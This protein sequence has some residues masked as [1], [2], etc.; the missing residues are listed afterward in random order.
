MIQN[1]LPALL[2]NISEISYDSKLGT[3]VPKDLI[4]DTIS[5]QFWFRL[6]YR[7]QFMR[8][9]NCTMEGEIEFCLSIMSDYFQIL[10]EKRDSSGHG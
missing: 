7:Q 4:F 8:E 5:I 3:L 10:F 9:Q 2:Q 6:I 1:D